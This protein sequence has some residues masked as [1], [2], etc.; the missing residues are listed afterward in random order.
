MSNYDCR[1][2]FYESNA[3]AQSWAA[4]DEA[5]NS[6]KRLLPGPLCLKKD[7]FKGKR[8]II[9]GA[10]IAGLT[11]AYELLA[12]ETGMQVTVLEAQNRTGGRC[13]SLRTGDT[14]IE[15]K[16]SDLFGSEP[17]QPQVVRFKQPNGDG[18]PYLNA[19]PGRIPSAHIR[20]LNYLKRFGV[21]IEVYV[22]NSMSNLVQR[23][24]MFDG[25]PV[26]YRRLD[27]NTRG[28]VAQMIYERAHDLLSCPEYGIP[29]DQLKER[30]YQ[31][32]CLMIDF[33][34]LIAS[35]KDMGKYSPDAGRPGFEEARSRAGFSVLP[36]I[37]PGVASKAIKLNTLLQSEF[38]MSTRFY[39]PS[40]FLWQPT[41]FQPAGG[42][43]MVE[44]SFALKVAELGGDI[45]VNRPVKYVSWDGETNEFI[46]VAC[47]MGTEEV[48]EY[49][50]D[51]C[52]SNIAMPF[53]KYILSDELQNP[54]SPIGFNSDFKTALQAVYKAQFEPSVAPDRDG[55]VSRFLAMTTKVGWQAERTL[56]QGEDIQN[57]YDAKT[58][59]RITEFPNSEA[60]VVPI[61]G[62]I[63][64]TD[65]PINQIWYPSN[66]YN[67]K[68]GVLTGAYNFSNQAYKSG[69]LPVCERLRIARE[70]ARLFGKKFGDGLRD[71][72]AIA[73]QN[74]P[75]IK[76]GWGQWH[77]VDDAVN[78]FNVLTQGTVVQGQGAP[79]TPVFFIV[80]D[81]V[82]SL[83]GWQEGAI[84]SALM[85]LSR[86]SRP[87][88]AV[89]FL[90]SLPDTRLMV[91][92]I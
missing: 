28:L 57:K 35:G 73:W 89:P 20:V 56:W 47:L 34:Q 81:Q 59:E 51:Y 61:Y 83:P 49:R 26:V 5:T 13:L 66:D 41:L 16:N 19:G 72:V 22:M 92:G 24:K 67:S 2:K 53:L 21:E 91:E 32:R 80:G 63:S 40:D 88:L 9:L 7:Q 46:V 84:A 58:D 42:M 44:H 65:H 69:L 68:L 85:A 8:A 17:G 86:L 62:G 76:G 70:G 1:S 71:G 50:A 64:W 12:Q 37:G 79:N 55:F 27:H 14:V 48:I 6:Q 43:D 3:G 31:L 87:D 11:T 54:A 38:W 90:K 77:V 74:M 15:D 29:K 52:F 30:T 23:E 82:S 36:G 60:G 25:Q 10:G 18:K 33:G 78:N 45:L 39:Q 4:L 75:Y